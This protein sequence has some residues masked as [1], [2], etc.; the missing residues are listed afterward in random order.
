MMPES[1]FAR[2]YQEIINFCKTNGAF[3]PKTMG[4]V[5]NVG[6]MAQKAEEYGSHDKTFE[7]PEDGD[8]NFVDVDT[9]EVLLTQHVEAGDIW[10]MCTVKDAPIRDWVKLAVTRARNSG[11]PA[12]FWLDPYRPHENELIKKVNLYLKDHD[13]EGLDIQIMSQVRSMRY[14][15]ERI[16][17]GHG[18][19]RR[20]RQHPARLP[21]RPV[22]DPGTRHQRQDAL[23]RAAHGRRR[24]VRDGRRRFRAQARQAAGGG[25][26]PALGFAR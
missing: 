22:P 3:D 20:D 1:T 26:P 11:M 25:E 24:H 12:L 2:I 13:T 14:T 21:H 23:D 15:L 4:T 16:I 10:R 8:A 6:L 18:H 17:R 5:P 9:G 7:I 19:H